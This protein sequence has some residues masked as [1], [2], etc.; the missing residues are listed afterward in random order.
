MAEKGNINVQ[1]EN[2][3]PIIKKFLY[4]EHDIF[5][6]ELV[7]NAVDATQK[8]KVLAAKGE[9]TG[10]IGEPVIKIDLNK[11]KKTITITDQGIGMTEEDVKKYIN[12]IALSSAQDF[13]DKYKDESNIIGH[14]GLGFYSAFMVASNV[15]FETLSYKEGAEAVHWSC[16]GSPNYSI[17]K[18]KKKTRGT[19]ITLHIDDDSLEFLEEG[20]LTGVLNKFCKFL[21][22]PIKFKDE[23]INNPNPAWSQKPADLTDED[24][25]NFYSELYPVSQPPLFHIHLNVDYPFN[26]T[27]VLYFPKLTNQFESQKNK[28]QLYSNQVFVTDSV[29]DIVP[30]YLTMLHGVLDSP[31]IPLN[32][33]RSYL[34]GDPNVKKISN[35]ISKKV[36]DKLAE[37]YKNDRKELEDNWDDIGVFVKY[38]MLSDEKFYERAINFCQFKNV[39]NKSYTWEEYAKAIGENQKDKDGNTIVLY[40]SAKQQQDAYIKAATE[41]NYD[42]VVMDQLIDNHFINALESKLE[43]VQFKRVDADVVDNLIDKGESR[44]SVLNEEQIT[45]LKELFTGL[46]GDSKGVTVTV[47]TKALSPKEAPIVITKPE[48]MRRMNDMSALSGMS[49]MGDLNM[50]SLVV[51]TNHP[52]ASKLLVDTDETIQKDK[53][54]HLYDLALLSQNMLKGE[55]L[56]KF[57][58]NSVALL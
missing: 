31:D 38:G 43:K 56:T 10:E 21:P 54:K 16:D 58:A 39:D 23:Q 55:S 2:I 19:K 33:S 4:S 11:D 17:K 32:V 15:E 12:Q 40:T 9:K 26:L 7:S 50:Y 34:Q 37:I 20:T 8:L 6:R 52:I 18:S 41:Q 30:E 46:V 28:I 13:L 25:K 5:I 44:E 36:A 45:S 47:E 29:E 1:T 57:V 14:F 49:Q 3:F 51:N 53:A 27:G 48:F 42:V 35:H 24:Y 22:I